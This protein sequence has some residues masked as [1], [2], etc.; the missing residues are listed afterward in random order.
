[1][2]VFIPLADGPFRRFLAG[3]KTVEIR[4]ADSPV[5]RQV[6]KACHEGELTH[7]VPTVLSRGYAKAWRLAAQ[8]D[9]VWDADCLADLPGEVLG[10]ADLDQAAGTSQFFQAEKP[11]LALGLSALQGE[12]GFP[13]QALA[14]SQPLPAQRKKTEGGK[15]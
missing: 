8:L 4:S 6:N 7:P 5:G 12:G 14:W 13:Y 11:V 2:T 1:M 15:P 3:T 9:Q 10:W